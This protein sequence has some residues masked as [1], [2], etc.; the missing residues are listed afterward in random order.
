MNKWFFEDIFL[1]DIAY[2]NS[3]H[4]C[5]NINLYE[6]LCPLSMQDGLADSCSCH[7]H[8]F[9]GTR[10]CSSEGDVFQSSHEQHH[11]LNNTFLWL[12]HEF[13]FWP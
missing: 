12:A 13:H 4:L 1:M 7:Q 5:E 10:D 3:P 2:V 8:R 11:I 9:Q 6:T